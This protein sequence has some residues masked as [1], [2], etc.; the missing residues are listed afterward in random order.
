MK[1]LRLAVTAFLTGFSGAMMPGPMLALT[2]AQVSAQG[3]AAVLFIC[4]GHALLELVIVVLL[5][6]GLRAVLQ[7][8]GIRGAIGILGG[9]ALLWMGADMVRAA[10]EV[11]LATASAK[12]VAMPW[13]QLMLAGAAVCV[14]NPYF[15]GWWATIGAGQM[16]QFAPRT[17]GEYLALYWGHELSDLAWYGLVGAL[18]VTG[19][20]LLSPNVHHGLILVCGALIAALGGTFVWAGIQCA[21][22]AAGNRLQEGPQRA[23]G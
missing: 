23:D 6:V 20:G 14:A 9:A 12:A 17:A 8:P 22:G 5:I 2:I 10:A 3:F 13:P 1:P 16:A 11:A 21:K 18:L 15:T 7:R 19:K 4:A